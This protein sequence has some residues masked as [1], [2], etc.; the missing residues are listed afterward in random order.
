[1]RVE[2]RDT[3]GRFYP[4]AQRLTAMPQNEPDALLDRLLADVR[5]YVRGNM[6]DDATLLAVC[7]LPQS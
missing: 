4:L 5:I 7:H 1:M 6:S 3:T 2:V